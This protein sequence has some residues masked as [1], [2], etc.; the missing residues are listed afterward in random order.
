MSGHRGQEKSLYLRGLLL[1]SIGHLGLFLGIFSNLGQGIQSTPPIIYSVSLEGGKSLGGISQ[2][3]RVNKKEDLAPP[4]KVQDQKT[5]PRE[6]RV[7]KD[8]EVSLN[9]EKKKPTPAPTPEPTPKQTPKPQSTPKPKAT[10]APPVKVK[11]TPKPVVKKEPTLEEIN[12]KLQQA[13]QRY[14]GESSQA[15]GQ[16]FGAGKLG[17]SG[18]GGGVQRPPAFFH[19]LKTLET[20]IKSGWRWH[21]DRAALESRVCFAISEQ[22]ELSQIELCGASGNHEYDDSVLRA[23]YKANPVPPPP[24][25]VYEYFKQVRMTFA[26]QE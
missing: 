24:A 3:S 5:A 15:G 26:A 18:M 12:K 21:D 17:G 2:V 13:V 9:E 8:A 1:S 20:Y 4:K 7:E 10:P 23:L 6:Q 22:G 14:A 19:Y 16:G 11:A 25:E